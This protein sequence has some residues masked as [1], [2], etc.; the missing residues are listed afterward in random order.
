MNFRK[1]ISLALALLLMTS[2]LLG[3]GSMPS[4]SLPAE[5]GSASVPLSYSIQFVYPE[6]LLE[7]GQPQ[8][9]SQK[10]IARMDVPAGESATPPADFALPEGMVF[11]GWDSQAY[12]AVAADAVI[13]AQ[14]APA[15]DSTPVPIAPQSEPGAFAFSFA[16]ALEGGAVSDLSQW[17]FYAMPVLEAKISFP[18]VN[19]GDIAAHTV[20]ITAPA[21]MCFIVPTDESSG[22]SFRT[23]NAD[24]TSV[25]LGLESELVQGAGLV[26][27]GLLLVPAGVRTAV[28]SSKAAYSLAYARL[29]QQTGGR[30]SFTLSAKYLESGTEVYTG[31]AT[32]TPKAFTS[33]QTNAFDRAG[34][35]N[36]GNSTLPSNTILYSRINFGRSRTPY[37]NNFTSK[38][39]DTSYSRFV[40]RQNRFTTTEK[41]EPVWDISA[42]LYLPDEITT[43]QPDVTIHTDGGGRY[44]LLG[45]G[46]VESFTDNYNYAS[47][48]ST[49]MSRL[50]TSSKNLGLV[51]QDGLDPA[52]AA[53]KG[54]TLTGSRL[55]V[56][57]TTTGDDGQAMACTQTIVQS[58]TGLTAPLYT[59][60][61]ATLVD[62]INMSLYSGYNAGGFTIK[63]TAEADANRYVDFSAT[64]FVAEQE[65]N[66]THQGGTLTIDNAGGY[67]LNGIAWPKGTATDNMGTFTVTYTTA[68]NPTPQTAAIQ[69][70]GP[71]SLSF[72]GQTQADYVNQ[73]VF[74]FDSGHTE[75][76]SALN[77]RF[78]FDLQ[79]FT[80]LTN[81]ADEY[82]YNSSLTLTLQSP[83][84]CATHGESPNL[85]VPAIVNGK[86]TR[87]IPVRI[88]LKE[89]DLLTLTTGGTSRNLYGANANSP[90]TND[91]IFFSFGYDS[92]NEAG[93]YAEDPTAKIIYENFVLDVG[94]AGSYEN[95]LLNG[96]DSSALML[97]RIRGNVKLGGGLFFENGS[98]VMT[99]KKNPTPTTIPLGN[100]GNVDNLNATIPA[101]KTVSLN[102]AADD[103][104]TSLVFKADR[105]R[106]VK[107]QAA[108]SL[109]ATVNPGTPD[110]LTG[111]SP[112]KNVTYWVANSTTRHMAFQTTYMRSFPDGTEILHAT[113][114][115]VR[116]AMSADNMEGPRPSNVLPYV[117]STSYVCQFNMYQEVYPSSL[118]S[119]TEKVVTEG[120]SFDL[121][122]QRSTAY[123]GAMEDADIWL[124]LKPQFAYL[125]N[126]LGLASRKIISGGKTYI[127]LQNPGRVVDSSLQPLM[128]ELYARSFTASSQSPFDNVWLDYTRTMSLRSE[129]M[130]Q[131]PYIVPF[132]TASGYWD[133]SIAS[134]LYPGTPANQVFLSKSPQGVGKVKVMPALASG[135]RM[136]PIAGGTQGTASGGV[137]QVLF[138]PAN[139]DALALGIS[140]DS[141]SSEDP[142]PA[143]DFIIHID[144]PK[145]GAD[146][147]M[148]VSGLPQVVL[149][150]STY[151]VF[152]TVNGVRT[153]ADQ[154]DP[155][156][157]PLVTHVEIQVTGLTASTLSLELP[158][159]ADTSNWQT[160]GQAS[161]TA[162]YERRQSGNP[163]P[164]IASVTSVFTMENTAQNS[165]SGKVFM[166]TAYTGEYTTQSQIYLTPMEV[167]LY[168]SGQDTPLQT[169]QTASGEY[170][171][172]SLPDGDYVIATQ[173][174]H[175]WARTTGGYKF[176][177]VINMSTTGNNM[178]PDGKTDVISLS[179]FSA[180]KGVN[181]GI[182][183]QGVMELIVK[184]TDAAGPELTRTYLPMQIGQE[185]VALRGGQLTSQV[186]L[187]P[188][189]VALPGQP[190][191]AYTPTQATWN[192]YFK[193]HTVYAHW[194]GV[195]RQITFSAQNTRGETVDLA[196][197]L[198][199][200]IEVRNGYPLSYTILPPEGADPAHT[201]F[202]GYTINGGALQQTLDLEFDAVN[203]DTDI[204]L[205]Y[206]HLRP[207]SVT[208]HSDKGRFSGGTSYSLQDKY[209]EENL[210]ENE[211]PQPD[212]P[213]GYTF[214][215]WS[216]A[217]GGA[218]STAVT[219]PVVLTAAD[220]AQPLE[221]YA[222]WAPVTSDVYY[223][224][225]G[226]SGA[227]PTSEVVFDQSFTLPLS[228]FAKTGYHFLGWGKA[229]GGPVVYQ[230]GAHIHQWKEAT[231]ITLYAQWGPKTYTLTYQCDGL[232]PQVQQVATGQKPQ[233]PVEPARTGYT[234]LGWNT[235]FDGS[236]DYIDPAALQSLTAD[237]T[238]YAQFEEVVPPVSSS[239]QPQSQ[240]QSSGGGTAPT[241]ADTTPS[242][243]AS[244]SAS[245]A[246]PPVSS[247]PVS[248]SSSTSSR[249]A[250]SASVAASSSVSAPAEKPALSPLPPLDKPGY[251]LVDNRNGTFTVLD[252]S[253]EPAE[254]WMQNPDGTIGVYDKEG[255]PAGTW[256]QTPEGE[257]EFIN[258]T[259]L[260]S[261]AL[262]Q[263]HWALANM[264]LAL[265]SLG[266][267]LALVTALVKKRTQPLLG[268]VG[269]A[270]AGISATLLL[271]T[272]NF[273]GP[274]VLADS[275]T[276]ILALVPLFQGALWF[277][278][279]K[280]VV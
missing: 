183:Y 180:V 194:D 99:T 133:T 122:I 256:Q 132:V 238:L 134:T 177:S 170:S 119:S 70:T 88:M 125:G 56:S 175:P 231:A 276:V 41:Y 69:G 37:L 151:Q 268:G 150:S 264:L 146:F 29:Y 104:L 60:T 93:T 80:G 157:Y 130:T 138:R 160:G 185:T 260:A 164:H 212:A 32:L 57:Y 152:Y 105:V 71:Y 64:G 272:S 4:S 211:A 73:V 84:G 188:D 275:W 253:G 140:I 199:D 241:P 8:E 92:R 44:I 225:N 118:T 61:P 23:P 112:I 271:L 227:I 209:E 156:D 36:S 124:Q 213:A 155:A 193:S 145:S 91:Q 261:G 216:T 163:T 121:N 218:P 51:L 250:S 31:S 149:G 85:S 11:T 19:Q 257:W 242:S 25:T 97:Q 113:P 10:E 169:M 95:P 236:G 229:P 87:V 7:D 38:M 17:D 21:G 52:S 181:I 278:G 26:N 202:L 143:N 205:I 39:T 165:I 200:T 232:A 221:F 55:E 116:G 279:K 233:P 49:D 98:F 135:L 68:Q 190:D 22:L 252:E 251:Q 20:E 280:K 230:D 179:N 255:Q 6:I 154:V 45:P 166:D 59:M 108:T 136:V 220:V 262:L 273:A 147:S 66:Q 128:L 204:R 111:R 208:F 247:E 15:P 9:L 186:T 226:G 65:V 81:P 86:H 142:P 265:L 168:K 206:K 12:E 162:S 83:G 33:S 246:R 43:N 207:V 174:A 109:G 24:F 67:F 94:T 5:S 75:S 117:N 219:F 237:L 222:L 106:V 198:P 153:P 228:T 2:L 89:R 74:H 107:Q 201:Y 129:L 184:D 248:S 58:G 172:T 137:T 269:V 114:Y 79:G 144:I 101:D 27:T 196:S 161:L 187:P 53:L 203:A 244:S 176:S 263:K 259:P 249:P 103:Y 270:A 30:P 110:A 3:A 16:N 82:Y 234:F 123:S 14:L 148:A 76:L 173:L 90:N 243:A 266:L 102:L 18:A 197:P 277:A 192:T 191:I 215:G 54:T 210:F 40:L 217:P 35:Q 214:A 139:S 50:F 63:T 167:A 28:S 235:K 77:N 267:A 178:R 47:Y 126:S 62:R 159:T 254:S 48:E 34:F 240:S 1:R 182:T 96:K 258:Q 223:N 42:K 100:L 171:F 195:L 72:P 245:K 224:G 120:N 115:V 239:S 127:C 46:G 13:T 274:M 141:F 189:T 131:P 78:T 158:L